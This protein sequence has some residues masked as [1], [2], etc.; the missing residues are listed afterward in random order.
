MNILLAYQKFWRRGFNFAD[1]SSRD[2]F[3]CA[4][5]AHFMV[6]FI[7]A[8][9][10]GFISQEAMLRP[11]S[12]PLTAFYL[13]A[14]LF[15]SLTI[16]VRRLRDSGRNWPWI[17]LMYVPIIGPIGLIFLLVQPSIENR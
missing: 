14:S 7:L 2:D 13:F 4:I 1:L 16:T 3:W 6:V 17:L 9:L 5:L 11:A 12:G 15:P 10:E 8:W